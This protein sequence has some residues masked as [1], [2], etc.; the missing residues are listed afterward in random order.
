MNTSNCIF[1]KFDFRLKTHF[2]FPTRNVKNIKTH[3]FKKKFERLNSKKIGVKLKII[4]MSFP[5]SRKFVAMHNLNTNK[6]IVD[7]IKGSIP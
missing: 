2:S 6:L 7:C 3:I 1:E 4:K 5:N